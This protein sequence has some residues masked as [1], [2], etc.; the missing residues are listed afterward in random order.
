MGMFLS[1][2][3]VLKV[4]GSTLTNWSFFGRSIGLQ[5]SSSCIVNLVG[6]PGHWQYATCMQCDCSFSR[7]MLV[8]GLLRL[9]DLACLVFCR[10]SDTHRRGGP[11]PRSGGAGSVG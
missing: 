3:S 9:L 6:L 2:K 10:G 5:F 11:P 4:C 8:Y 7:D 1:T